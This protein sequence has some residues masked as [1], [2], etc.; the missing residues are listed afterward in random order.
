MEK[1]Q[2]SSAI[3]K[4][5]EF[6][7]L[8]SGQLFSYIGDAYLILVLLSIL[9]AFGGNFAVNAGKLLFF[10]T[11]PSLLFGY[12]AG[13]LSD[14]YSRKATM[15]SSVI[16]RAVLLF[17]L[18]A[19]FL[20]LSNQNHIYILALLTGLGTVIFHPA[21]QSSIPDIVQSEKLQ[22]A[23][24]FNFM[25]LI[26]AA[27]VSSALI[28]TYFG[29]YKF[30]LN[31][32][33]YLISTIILSFLNLSPDF[34]ASNANNLKF[35]A[36]YL[37]NHKNTRRLILI[38]VALTLISASFVNILFFDL[39]QNFA[40]TGMMGLD[41]YKILLAVGSVVLGIVIMTAASAKIRTSSMLIISLY[42]IFAVSSTALIIN[43]NTLLVV[44]ML[45][46][47]I[48]NTSMVITIDTL[49][50]KIVPSRILG[51][52]F[53][54]KFSLTSLFFL[55][56]TV[57]FA[58]II[59][60]TSPL[61]LFKLVSFTSLAVAI[62]VFHVDDK[63]RHFVSRKFFTGIFR[64]FFPVEVLGRENLSKDKPIIIAGNHT[65]WVD[66]LIIQ[67]AC[68]R[69]VW[70]ITGPVAFNLPVVKHIIKYFNVIPLE[71]GKGLKALDGGVNKL[72][73]GEV[74]CIFPEGRITEDGN[75]QKFNRGV[76]ILHKQSKVPIVPFAIQGGR[77]AWA[78]DKAAPTFR[79][80]V[81]QFDTPINMPE[82]DEKVIVNELR[83]RVYNLKE[84]LE[85]RAKN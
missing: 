24:S 45:L 61:V 68:K 59:S 81:I 1:A 31:G 67:T 25:S 36:K 26:I 57:T 16:Y 9:P 75:L 49:L 51:N 58:K 10:F 48:A 13:V 55:I 69:P 66:T 85:E 64:I 7:K 60:M 44:W 33:F 74:I 46:T 39:S 62:A 83:T 34:E 63:F 3:F 38:S 32:S 18:P 30:F 12:F 65:G 11:L 4:N 42:G 53:G 82:D 73:Q 52:I 21:K 5:K 84:A 20:N 14:I 72:L 56:S 2:T 47:A 17:A 28:S 50:Q 77:E 71:F 23:N 19:L 54:L 8:W 35:L 76:S 41:S 70:Y 27:F 37:R 43:N 29:E 78:F 80:V 15:I 22:L 79:K 6:L 40:R